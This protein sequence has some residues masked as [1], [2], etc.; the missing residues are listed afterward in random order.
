MPLHRAGNG[1]EKQM[2]E[3]MRKR[4]PFVSAAAG[5]T[6]RR[7]YSVWQTLACLV[8]LTGLAATP[9]KADMI[10]NCEDSAC[11][12]YYPAILVD[13]DPT[14]VID[15]LSSAKATAGTYTVNGMQK[16]STPKQV[17]DQQKHIQNYDGPTGFYAT[18]TIVLNG[19]KVDSTKS[20]VTFRTIYYTSSGSKTPSSFTTLPIPITD[21]TLTGGKVT[22]FMFSDP[23]WYPDI[24]KYGLSNDGLSGII[25]LKTGVASYMA[26]YKSDTNGVISTY[27]V[28]G[29]IVP[30]PATW[31]ML[32]GILCILT[33]VHRHHENGA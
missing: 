27:T 23:N 10:E 15:G 30:E 20:M 25:N 4:L 33:L 3:I 21:A 19:G 31:T 7:R 13:A 17:S 12:A 11:D 29:K 2:E 28:V 32:L 22:S 24:G 9:A 1:A 6:R 26:A 14:L 5:A 16:K 18:Y 8:F